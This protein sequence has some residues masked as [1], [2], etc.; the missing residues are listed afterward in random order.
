MGN[1]A[2]TTYEQF[3]SLFNV[4]NSFDIDFTILVNYFDFEMSSTQTPQ[5]GKVVLYVSL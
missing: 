1:L 4:E 3:I 5:N 2:F